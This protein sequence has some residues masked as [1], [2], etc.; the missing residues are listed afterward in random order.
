M[1]KTPCQKFEELGL[2]EFEGEKFH[3]TDKFEKLVSKAVDHL[4]DVHSDIRRKFMNLV[5]NP[6]AQFGSILMGADENMFLEGATVVCV[7]KDM[8]LQLGIEDRELAKALVKMFGIMIDSGE[9]QFGALVIPK[10]AMDAG[11]DLVKP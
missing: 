7:A 10:S 2:I 11:K 4:N 5:Q 6:I 1:E 9:F 8:L 3:K